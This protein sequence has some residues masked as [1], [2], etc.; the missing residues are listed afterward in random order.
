[1]PVCLPNLNPI[2]YNPK[3]NTDLYI[4]IGGTLLLL[5]AMQT[6]QRKNLDRW[7]ACVLFGAYLG[8][9][10]YLVIKEL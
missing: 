10:V 7:E 5:I 1:L 4:L 2:E 9:T 6:G 8:Y 3:F